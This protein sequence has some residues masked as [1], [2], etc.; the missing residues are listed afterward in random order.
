[1]IIDGKTY[2]LGEKNYVRLESDKSLIVLGH[3]NNSEMK[4]FIGWQKRL[5]GVYKKTAHF[6]ILRNGT[7]YQHFDTKYSSEYFPNQSLNN[8]SIIILLENEGY[9]TK[10]SETNEFITWVGDIYKEKNNIV[11][12]KW[13]NLNFW[14]SY[15]KEQFD[16]TIELVK[17]ICMNHGIPKDSMNHNTKV[18]DL[19]G[20]SGIVYKANLEKFYTDL[21]PTWNFQ[22]FKTKIENDER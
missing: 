3:T 10:D 13:R 9:L 18:N 16:S 22:L 4:H 5:G 14:V 2:Q 15:T 11:E 6:T 20:F 12:K 21:N 19:G 1:M 17:S 7:I 8:K